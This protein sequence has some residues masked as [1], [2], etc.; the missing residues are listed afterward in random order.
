[1][2]MSVQ[3]LPSHSTDSLVHSIGWNSSVSKAIGCGWTA[4]VRFSFSPPLCPC[5]VWDSHSLLY[6]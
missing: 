6:K 3:A 5:K 2:S 4:R 1:M